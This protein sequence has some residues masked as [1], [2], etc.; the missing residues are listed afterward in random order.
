MLYVAALYLHSW[1]RWSVLGLT[2]ATFGR[3]VAGLLG[4]KAWGPSDR[5]LVRFFV[6]AFDIDVLV[7]LV[8]YG[9]SG[10]TP[11]SMADLHD[12]MHIAV[13]RFF[14]VEHATFAVF[15]LVAAHVASVAARRATTDPA[16]W[17][18]LAIGSGIALALVLATI[19]WPMLAYGRPLFRL[20]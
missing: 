8:L 11:K 12:C 9:V 17:K 13:L 5:K 18:R 19:P 1:L 15:A 2:V 14:A 20:S 7:G 6:A 10:V 16:R 4:K 3:A